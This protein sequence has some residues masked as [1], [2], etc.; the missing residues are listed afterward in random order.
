VLKDILRQTRQQYK[1]PPIDP[2]LGT[3]VLVGH[4]DTAAPSRYHATHVSCMI[5]MPSAGC[6]LDAPQLAGVVLSVT[7]A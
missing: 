5:Q 2:L 4:K 7:T 3:D 6:R 1:L